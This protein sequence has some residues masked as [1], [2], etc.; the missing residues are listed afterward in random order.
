MSKSDHPHPSVYTDKKRLELIRGYRV[1]E[2]RTPS[3]PVLVATPSQTLGPFFSLGLI[4]E[5]DDDL[6]CRTPGGP[7]AE[8]A[9]IVVGGRVLDE[10]GKPVRKAL[11]EVWQANCRGKYE[12]PDDVTQ[13]LPDP[14]L[15]AFGRM[16]T[17]EDGSYRFRSIKPGAYPNP[18][19]DNWMRPPHIHYSIFAAGVMQRL[20]TQMYFPGE[21]LNDIDPIL[22]GIEDLDARASLIARE[23]GKGEYQFDIVLRGKAETAF[24]VDS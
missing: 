24:L 2:Q 12:H 8:G 20:I 1:H 19:Y 17:A 21:P 16:L 6:A 18:G 22:N 11:I 5:G 9:P 10:D 23:S 13:A 14:N 3:K 15:K 4:R 7:R